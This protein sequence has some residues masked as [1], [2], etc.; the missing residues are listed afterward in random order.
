MMQLQLSQTRKLT[1]IVAIMIAMV[2][3]LQGCATT[4][5]L[6]AEYDDDACKVV[7]AEGV[8][9]A[10]ERIVVREVEYRDLLV[11]HPAVYFDYKKS[12]L[13]DEQND[14]LLENLAVLKQNRDLRIVVRGFTDEVG[15][16]VYNRA[17]AE[18][19]VDFV[20][21]YLQDQGI[22]PSRMEKMPLGEELPF[23]TVTDES[24]SAISRRV[25]L[26]LVDGSGR[27]VAYRVNQAVNQEKDKAAT[28]SS[29]QEVADA[30]RAE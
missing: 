20:V 9:L 28:T 14:R 4:E 3:S 19:R 11:W 27:P 7:V 21:N 10:P 5:E 12:S 2:I 8:Q 13:K 6:Y 30:E 24:R 26:L 29:D 17:L 16:R 15:S 22:N 25:E 1:I 23:L 18:R